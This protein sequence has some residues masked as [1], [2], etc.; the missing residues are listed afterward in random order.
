MC[1]W[2]DLSVF[3]FVS[4]CLKILECTDAFLTLVFFFCVG[5][6][7]CVRWIRSIDGSISS[8]RVGSEVCVHIGRCGYVSFMSLEEA[9]GEY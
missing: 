8:S 1:V 4:G 9:G 7:N 5:N 3:V 6:K 2:P